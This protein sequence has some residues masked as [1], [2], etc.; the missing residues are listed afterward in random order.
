MSHGG[1]IYKYAKILECESDEI[2]D[3]SSNINCYDPQTSIT[4][5]NE[6]ITKYADF[7]YKELKSV[8]AQNYEVKK[9]QIAL[10]NG[11]TSAIY[12][13]FRSI[14]QKEVYLYAPLY[15]EYEKAAIKAKKEIY[16]ISR[17]GGEM[18]DDVWDESIVVFVNPATPD[19]TYYEKEELDELFEMWI[20][21]EC[22]IIIDESFLEFEVL[23][24]VRSKINEY[25]KL[26]IIQSFS[27]FYS[28]AGVRIGAVFSNKKNIEKLDPTIWNIS[29]LDAAFLQQRLS[30]EEFK[31][32]AKE[33]HKQQKQELFD[34]LE[35]SNLFEQVFE[36]DANFFLTKTQRST[37]IF[38]HLLEHKIL[39]RRCFDFDYLDNSF[40]R[41]AVK[42]P[43]SHQ[44]LQE[45]FSG[46]SHIENVE[47][48]QEVQ[49]ET[50]LP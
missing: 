33:F 9:S 29:S 13:L 18:N 8:I 1:D 16:K 5:T 26:Y 25:K 10:F 36:S 23:E 40:L 44:K 15:S 46:L 4:L 3:F 20:E 42:D 31:A 19:G 7:R 50:P 22:T 17:L 38:N 48:N 47:H 2:I 14:K 32:Q 43:F 21:R 34:I 41:F 28:C 49:D 35:N 6:T 24:S 30:D 12:E 39:V 37:E 27:K 11:A 45:A